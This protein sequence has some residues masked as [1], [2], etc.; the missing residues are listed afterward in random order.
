M[1]RRL[2]GECSKL[3][4]LVAVLAVCLVAAS[5]ASGGAS[6]DTLGSDTTQDSP[7]DTETEGADG[8]GPGDDTESGDDAE[9]DGLESGGP[10]SSTPGNPVSP[11]P[12][13]GEPDGDDA[14]PE[15]SLSDEELDQRLADLGG[16]LAVGNGPEL[17]VVRPDGARV[18]FLDGSET[19]LAA[20]P[21]WSHDGSQLAWSSVSAE[22][23][24][25]QV[26]LFDDDGFRSGDPSSADAAGTPVF[27]LQWNEADERLAYIRNSSG[28][29]AVEVGVVEPGL[30]LTPIG[31]G[32]PFFISWSPT[33][34][35]LLGHVNESSIE[36]Y[37][38]E[39]VDES[40]F[41]TVTEVTGGFS[42]PAWVD[43]Q[44]A[45]IVSEGQLWYLDAET[46]T[47]EPIIDLEGPVRFVLSPDRTRLAYQTLGRLGGPTVIAEPTQQDLDGLVV[48]DL[49]TLE[50]TVVTGVTAA[51]WEW[52]PDSQSLA[53]LEAELRDQRP[54]GRWNFWSDS[55]APATARSQWFLFTRK[56]GQSYLPFFAQ[57]T[58]SVT[59]WAPDSSAFA[60]AGAIGA[61]RG[62]WIQLVDELV[63]PRN[64][65]PGDYVTWGPGQPPPPSRATSAA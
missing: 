20:Q 61:E 13:P 63:R 60:F 30:S 2:H 22:R 12:S 15:P 50:K 51:A 37:D 3:G 46:G 9:T 24:V 53:W 21:T 65:A 1:V 47:S 16:R 56:Y 8:T 34:D 14:I 4:R 59:G 31:N 17:A 55:Q 64:V 54:A 33:P 36:R 39:A 57:Y 19:V 40:G 52:S 26:Q 35:R 23:Q 5:C 38:T 27:Y 49:A 6:D 41:T 7:D 25:V 48:L 29:G 43:D 45:L 58:Q 28:G 18:D 32:A 42:A 44:R 10:D 62:V 11:T